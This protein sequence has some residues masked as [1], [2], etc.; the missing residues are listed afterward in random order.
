MRVIVLILWLFISCKASHPASK[1][2][3]VPDH[4]K[5]PPAIVYKTKKDYTQNVPVSLSVD[6]NVIVSYPGKTDIGGEGHFPVPSELSKGYLLDNRGINKNVAFLKYSYA[7]YAA[8][9]KIPSKEEMFDLIID[10]DPLMELCDCGS[11][12][13]F[14][15]IRKQLNQLIE[16]KQLRTVCRV[17]K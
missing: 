15:D 1:V 2:E 9:D 5:G 17:V 11:Q 14:A 16:K 6:K 10:A 12:K 13:A 7:E 3:F 4:T 8:L